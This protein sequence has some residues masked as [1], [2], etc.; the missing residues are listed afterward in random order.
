MQG[1]GLTVVERAR[2]QAIFTEQGVRLTHSPDDDSQILHVGRLLGADRVIFVEVTDRPAVDTQAFVYQ[3]YGGARHDAVY[4]MSVAV[5]GVEVETSEIRWSGTAQ[6]LEA[7]SNP[8]Q[9]AVV[10]AE[11]AIARATCPIELGYEWHDKTSK[12]EEGWCMKDGRTINLLDYP[13]TIGPLL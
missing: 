7:I 11:L 13:L 1:A 2:L 5:R 8:E 4:H 3:S 10:L 9:W 12:S 6:T